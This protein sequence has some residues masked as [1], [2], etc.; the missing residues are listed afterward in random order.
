[1]AIHKL[2]LVGKL[3]LELGKIIGRADDATLLGTAELQCE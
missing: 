1:M 2:V 3:D